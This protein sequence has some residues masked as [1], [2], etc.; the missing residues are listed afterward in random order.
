MSSE[1]INQFFESNIGRIFEHES[2][3]RAFFN[4][5]SIEIK[6]GVKTGAFTII[7]V[8]AISRDNFFDLIYG[9]R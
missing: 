5:K 3:S 8:P 4:K 2:V 7:F 1:G 9:N 6:K